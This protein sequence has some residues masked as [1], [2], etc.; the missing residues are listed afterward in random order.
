MTDHADIE[1]VAAALPGY[2]LGRG[3]FG[4]VL[5][6]RRQPTRAG[7]APSPRGLAYVRR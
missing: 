3:G 5:A 4:A 2:E 7:E 6:G 1:R